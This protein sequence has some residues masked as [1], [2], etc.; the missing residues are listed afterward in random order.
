MAGV[1]R[2]GGRAGAGSGA[3][4]PV[5]QEVAWKLTRELTPPAQPREINYDP[6][7]FQAYYYAGNKP[8]IHIF[9]GDIVHTW[10]PDSG[11]MD[12]DLKRV[13]LGPNSN[14]GPI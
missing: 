4:A 3:R 1:G 2:S 7:T 11:G 12:K 6:T 9:P 14:I 8:E 5:P 10:A 13:A